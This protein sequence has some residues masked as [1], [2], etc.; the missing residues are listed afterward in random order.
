MA[1]WQSDEGTRGT[2]RPPWTCELCGGRI[3]RP[4]VVL[5][6]QCHRQ[7]CKRCEVPPLYEGDDRGPICMRCF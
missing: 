1:Q 4:L 3:K 6:R 7:I 2:E 5:C